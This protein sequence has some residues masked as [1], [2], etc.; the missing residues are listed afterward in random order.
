MR[1][2]IQ[3]LAAGFLVSP[4]LHAEIPIAPG[5]EPKLVADGFKFTEGPAADAAGNVYF[6]D[7]PN[8]RICKWDAASGKVTDFMV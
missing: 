1:L 4:A 2:P 3:L 6:T 8:D 7:Q 5:S